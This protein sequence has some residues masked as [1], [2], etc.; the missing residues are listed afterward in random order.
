MNLTLKSPFADWA[1]NLSTQRFARARG[2]RSACRR[3]LE[4]LGGGVTSAAPLPLQACGLL[5]PYDIISGVKLSEL[6]N[7]V[8][9]LWLQDLPR[10]HSVPTPEPLD[11]PVTVGDGPDWDLLSLQTQFSI[12][13]PTVPGSKG[14]LLRSNQHLTLWTVENTATSYL[15]GFST[16]YNTQAKLVSKIVKYL[17]VEDYHCTVAEVDENEYLSVRQILL[18]LRNE[19]ATLHD[20]ILKNFEKIKT[21]RSTN[22][23][24]L[25]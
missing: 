17:Q 4:D 25:Y 9:E 23:D 16:Y 2:H 13:V 7:Q 1:V 8:Q 20:I 11:T 18:H 10:I 21:P 24:N 15:R 5:G 19:Y 22:T 12:K 14:Q 3:C 6:D